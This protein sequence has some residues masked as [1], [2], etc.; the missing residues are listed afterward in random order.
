MILSRK[1]TPAAPSLPSTLKDWKWTNLWQC[2]VPRRGAGCRT[3]R[4]YVCGFR[5]KIMHNATETC[6]T[7]AGQKFGAAA[8]LYYYRARYYDP[9]SGRFINADPVN[10]DG[11]NDFYLYDDNNSVNFTDPWGLCPDDYNL[12]LRNHGAPHID[13]VDPNGNLVGRYRPD[14]S[15]IPHK[16]KVPPRIPNSDKDKFQEAADELRKKTE[17]N[18]AKCACAKQPAQAPAPARPDLNRI[19]WS[20]C[21]S[22]LDCYTGEDGYLHRMPLGG[23]FF[24]PLPSPG[25]PVTVPSLP[26]LPIPEPIPVPIPIA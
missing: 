21:H 22:H 9:N 20:Q 25:V 8:S 6:T 3:R 23:P 11:G 15:G 4:S 17:G 24:T 5:V 7:F 13:R 2:C 12:D 1:L 26:P 10:F 18:N 14:G 19:P 16:G